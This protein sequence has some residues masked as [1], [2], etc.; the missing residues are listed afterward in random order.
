MDFRVA[1]Q[2]GIEKGIELVETA[3]RFPWWR[4]VATV[5]VCV[6]AAWLA[7]RMVSG[8]NGWMAYQK[9]RQEYRQ[10][11]QQVQQMQKE[12]AELAERVKALKND[13]KAIEREAR[14][15]LRYAKPGEVVYVLPEQKTPVVHPP[16]SGVAQKN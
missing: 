1:G 8:P 15:Q 5:A 2:S 4:R 3:R 16:S 9:K 10:L 14:E 6:L 11:Q 12:N 13:P 7:F